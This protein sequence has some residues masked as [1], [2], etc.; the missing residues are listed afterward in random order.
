MCNGRHQATRIFNVR[1]MAQLR[2]KKVPEAGPFVH[3]ISHVQDRDNRKS[4][5]VSAIASQVVRKVA[6]RG[7]DFCLMVAGLSFA[8]K[9]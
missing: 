5:G 1:K 8:G 7:F 2:Q 9:A 3:N 4:I 6:R